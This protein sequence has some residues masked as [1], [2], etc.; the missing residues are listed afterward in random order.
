MPLGLA[1]AG[2]VADA[3]GRDATLVTGAA[4]IV[5]SAAAGMAV[6]SVRG[7]RA[8]PVAGSA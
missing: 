6:P 3:I 5:S 7:L 8:P 1:L 4:L 2:P